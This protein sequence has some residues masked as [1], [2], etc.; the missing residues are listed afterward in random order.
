ML[1]PVDS[2]GPKVMSPRITRAVG[3]EAMRGMFELV[4]QCE[5]GSIGLC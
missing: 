2:S 4:S 5:S 1:L 3:L